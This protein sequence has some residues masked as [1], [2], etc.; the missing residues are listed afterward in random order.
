MTAS[1][2]AR[3]DEAEEAACDYLVARG[4]RVLARNVRLG[5]LEIDVVA[6]DGDVLAFVEVRSRQRG[7]RVGPFESVTATKRSRIVR[8]A[9]AYLRAHPEHAQERRVR[10]DVVAVHRGTRGELEVELA[11]GAFT[12]S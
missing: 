7:G 1:R 9:E 4:F 10:F 2:R 6:A 11:R 12:A 3:G 8:A 5:A